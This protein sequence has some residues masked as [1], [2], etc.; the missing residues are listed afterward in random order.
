MKPTHAYKYPYGNTHTC[1]H[2]QAHKHIDIYIHMPTHIPTHT[3]PS[4]H[5]HTHTQEIPHRHPKAQDWTL[6]PEP[7]DAVTPPCRHDYNL[8]L[9]V[10][11]DTNK[12]FIVNTWWLEKKNEKRSRFQPSRTTSSAGFLCEFCLCHP[13]LLWSSTRTLIQSPF[14]VGCVYRQPHCA[15]RA[16]YSPDGYMTKRAAEIWLQAGVKHRVGITF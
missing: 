8:N 7:C 14:L 16:L 6:N 13:G 11:T 12:A 3:H 10:L 2:M 9:C 1:A 15:Y 4:I 5:T